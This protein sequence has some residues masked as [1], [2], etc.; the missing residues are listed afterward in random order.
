[1][2]LLLFVQEPATGDRFLDKLRDA[3][4]YK[5]I[6]SIAWYLFNLSKKVGIYTAIPK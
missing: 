2:T 5:F 3:M 1:M 6:M 4:V